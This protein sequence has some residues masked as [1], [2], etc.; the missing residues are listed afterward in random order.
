MKRK[1]LSIILALALCIGL[2]VQALAEGDVSFES[3]WEVDGVPFS[4]LTPSGSAEVEGFIG[5]ANAGGPVFNVTAPAHL[6]ITTDLYA[7]IEK[8]TLLDN[9]KFSFNYDNGIEYVDPVGGYKTN[10]DGYNTTVVGSEFTLEKGAYLV[11][12]DGNQLFYV[13]VNDSSTVEPSPA[14]V[15]KPTSSTV[16]VNG[17]NVAFDAYNISGNNY[18]KLRD[19]AYVLNGSAKQFEV[20][21]DGAKNAITL[22]SGKVYTVVGGEMTGKGAG[23]KS[24]TATSSKIY[25]D[26]K[27]VIFTAYNIEGNNYFKLRDIGTAFDFG[28]TWDGAKNTIVIDTGSN[29]TT[30]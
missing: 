1:A 14:L 30:D 13:V 7:H 23:D 27:E 16:L 29:Y 17:E 26:G 19:L 6:V 25:L 3:M 15:A 12:G 18:F 20:S 4:D 28:V 10:D 9:G 8:T 2:T 21:W 22:T 11:W 24:P 5:S